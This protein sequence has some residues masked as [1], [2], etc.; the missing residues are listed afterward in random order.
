[1]DG[2]LLQDL[3]T[4]RGAASAHV[5]Q[6]ARDWLD[7]GESEDVVF[8]T[9]VREVIG[10]AKLTLETSSVADGSSFL[11]LVPTFSLAVGLRTDVV[12]ASMAKVPPMRFVRWNLTGDGSPWDATLRIW[13]AAHG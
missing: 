13:V 12:L 6:L 8:Y 10:S 11:P 1:V 9:H 7:I 5:V 2:L 4:I 3:I